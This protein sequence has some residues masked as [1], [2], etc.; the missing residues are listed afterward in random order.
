VLHP[1]IVAPS[2]GLSR[3]RYLAILRAEVDRPAAAQHAIR[4]RH[5]AVGA[6][7]E[8]PPGGDR[9]TVRR[10]GPPSRADSATRQEQP[11]DLPLLVAE[12]KTSG[13]AA[14]AAATTAPAAVFVAVVV[15]VVATLAAPALASEERWQRTWALNARGGGREAPTVGHVAPEAAAKATG[16]WP[17]TTRGQPEPLQHRRLASALASTGFRPLGPVLQGGF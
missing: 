1:L 14:A 15:V 8:V 12:A 11:L 9:G 5:R 3:R 17:C 10:Q 16:H 2:S 7:R 6:Q 13:A 4:R